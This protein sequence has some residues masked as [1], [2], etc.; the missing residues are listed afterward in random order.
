MHIYIKERKHS[1]LLFSLSKFIKKSHEKLEKN[2]PT[3]FVF[4]EKEKQ[5]WTRWSLEGQ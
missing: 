3:I 5:I 1:C 2:R 4:M